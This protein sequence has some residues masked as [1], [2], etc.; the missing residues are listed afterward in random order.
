MYTFLLVHKHI[1]KKK[2]NLLVMGREAVTN[3]NRG[4]PVTVTRFENGMEFTLGANGT[5]KQM[6]T[7]LFRM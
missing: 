4:N 6:R 1:I 5:N 2:K 7:I 3:E